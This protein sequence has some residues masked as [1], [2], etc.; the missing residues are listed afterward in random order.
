MTK[1]D[2]IHSLL[3]M[4]TSL[5][6]GHMAAQNRLYLPASFAAQW[7]HMTKFWPM[8]WKQRGGWQHSLK[9]AVMAFHPF[10]PSNFL[11]AGIGNFG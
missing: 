3:M 7:G 8:G 4:E 1:T 9:V 2:N 5:F 6:A 10:L 11:L